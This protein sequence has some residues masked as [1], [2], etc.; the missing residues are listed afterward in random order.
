MGASATNRAYEWLRSAIMTGELP[1]GAFVDEA[2]V[3]EAAGV[4]RTPVREAFQRLAGERV[5]QLVPRRGA[6]VRDVSPREVIEAYGARWLVESAAIRDV[7]ARGIDVAEAMAPILNEMERFSRFSGPADRATYIALDKTFH[8]VYVR[9]AGNSVIAQ[10]YDT[11]WPLH[12]WDSLRGPETSQEF[13][14]AV[15]RQHREI[16][17]RISAADTPGALAALEEH[18]TPLRQRAWRE[19]A[20]L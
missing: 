17:D 9:A 14:Q 4:S 11:L 13:L 18:L 19:E 5:I 2:T 15:N 8:S 20:A 10:F 3:C 12:E 16:F 7:L 6:Q 1:S